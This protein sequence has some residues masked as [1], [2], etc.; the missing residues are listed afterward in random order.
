MVLL[1]AAIVNCCNVS[2]RTADSILIACS[3]FNGYDVTSKNAP[4]IGL[5]TF[6]GLVV[7]NVNVFISTTLAT[8]NVPLDDK[9]GD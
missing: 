8:V 9:Y 5:L 4:T 3:Q 2:L 6:K 7:S 1:C